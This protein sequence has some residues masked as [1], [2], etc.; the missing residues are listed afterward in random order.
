MLTSACSTRIHLFNMLR[1]LFLWR[2]PALLVMYSDACSKPR[3]GEKAPRYT[4]CV[5]TLEKNSRRRETFCDSKSPGGIP[6]PWS[7]SSLAP[8]LKT[9]CSERGCK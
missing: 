7:A 8:S 4:R 3:A 9:Y 6:R 1:S 5:G 2:G